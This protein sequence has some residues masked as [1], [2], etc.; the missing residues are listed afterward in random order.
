MKPPKISVITPSLN[1]AG[2]IADAIESVLAQNHPHF[3]HIIV[4]GGSTDGTL[5]M[6][7]KYPYLHVIS[8]KDRGMYDAINRGLEIARG[9]I[10]CFLNSDDLLPPNVLPIIVRA[11]ETQPHV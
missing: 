4:D 5:E 3:E 10:I 7:T 11:L 2:M 1:R 9:E 6:L 8:G